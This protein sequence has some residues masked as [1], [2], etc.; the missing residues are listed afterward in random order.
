MERIGDGEQAIG[1]FPDFRELVGTGVDCAGDATGGPGSVG[2][3][4]ISVEEGGES[5]G[6]ESLGR[7]GSE[8]GEM[9]VI[10]SEFEDEVVMRCEE[11]GLDFGVDGRDVEE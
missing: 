11:L 5:F 1:F 9:I 6:V 8:I 2:E 3:C 4:G 10:W 7:E